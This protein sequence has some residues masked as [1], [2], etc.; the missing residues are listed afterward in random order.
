MLRILAPIFGRGS[1][2]VLDSG[3]C[4]LKG[5]LELKKRGVYASA[6][7]KKRRFW[8]KYIKGDDIKSQFD[9]KDVGD[10][11][12]VEFWGLPPLIPLLQCVNRL[13]LEICSVNNCQ[14]EQGSLVTLI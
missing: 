9:G 13:G 7:I 1:V 6:L 12:V 3:F 8:P 5:N 10:C 2:V 14:S 4:V 11:D